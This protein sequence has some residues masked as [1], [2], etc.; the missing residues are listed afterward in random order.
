M[1]D[2]DEPPVTKPQT[3]EAI[4][5]LVEILLKDE[6]FRRSLGRRMTYLILATLAVAAVELT[7]GLPIIT[8]ASTPLVGAIIVFLIAQV[9]DWIR[10]RKP[11]A[12]FYLYPQERRFIP[13]KWFSLP[14][15]RQLRTCPSC[16]SEL[17]KR[18]Q[19]GQHFI[20]SPDFE[21][22]DVPPTIDEFCPFCDPRLPKVQRTYV[23]MGEKPPS[24]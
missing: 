21:N 12:V 2:R 24:A 7:I 15:Y 13:I 14:R 18:R 19:Q 20:V 23:P 5:T 9:E 11:R 3:G 6:E 10:S 17:I 4:K 1:S 8:L 22:P 16:G